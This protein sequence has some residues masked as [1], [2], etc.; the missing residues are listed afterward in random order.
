I[1]RVITPASVFFEALH[2]DP[3]QVPSNLANQLR[4]LDL[5]APGYGRLLLGCE[6]ADARRWPRR[7]LLPNDPA[8]FIQTCFDQLFAIEWS[9]AREQFIQKHSQRINVTA[10]SY[11]ETAHLSLRR[12]HVTRR[13]DE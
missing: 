10:R 2:H 11:V 6:R 3:V 4:Q 5:S 7:L 9:L 12:T 13:A 8:D 1:C